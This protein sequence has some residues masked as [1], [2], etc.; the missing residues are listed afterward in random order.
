MRAQFVF[1]RE[2]FLDEPCL[3]PIHIFY[4][5]NTTA[6]RDCRLA[7]LGRSAGILLYRLG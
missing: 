7:Q 6:R 2:G 3:A 1:G 5:S 4:Q